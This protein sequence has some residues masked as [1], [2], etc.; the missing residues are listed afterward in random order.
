M[1]ESPA[2]LAL[3]QPRFI[4]L[5]LH[6]S[7][8]ML[9]GAI[10]VKAMAKLCEKAGVPAAALT[11]HGN[12]FGALEF[13]ETLAKAGVQ[14]IIGCLLPLRLES[15]GN[16]AADPTILLLAQSE[17]GYLHLLKLTSKSFLESGADSPHVLMEDL[18]R[19]SEGLIC[20][21]GGAD[22]PA[23]RLLRSDRRAMA[24]AHLEDLARLYPDRLYVEIQRH[25]TE[26]RKRAPDEEETE[27]AFL[28]M[29]YARDL[30]IVATQDTLYAAAEMAEAHDAMLCIASG[31]RVEDAERVR[32]TPE[33][34]FKSPEQMAA[35]FADLPEALEATVEIARRCAHRPKT[36]KPIL[37]RFAPDEVE[38]AR[39]QAEEGL[40]RRLATGPLYAAREA[41]EERLAYELS[42]IAR[43]G[44]SGY[45]LIVSDFI[46]WAKEQGIPVGPGRGSG[47]GSLVAWSLLITD[48]DPIRYG[49][50]FERFL[51]P[52]R[53]S[54]PDF[55][56]D[57]CQEKRH[58]VID[59]VQRKYGR[60]QVA[61]I[62]T[63]GK[64]QARAAL[65]DVGRVLNMPYGQV[66][67]LCKMVPN[68]P[69]KPV[70]I[71]E[72][73]AGEPR[74]R[75]EIR[76]HAAVAK[77]FDIATKLEGLYRHASTHAA[78]VVIGDRPLDELVPLYLDPRSEMPVTQFNMKWVE[79]AG[80]VKFDFLGLK[81]LSVIQEALELIPAPVDI[82]AIS[83][84]DDRTYALYSRAET[85]GVFQVEGTGMRDALRQLRPTSIE[86]IIALVALYRP[87]PMSNIPHYCAVKHGREEPEY[88]H[89]K[90]EPVLKETYGVIIYQEQVME[91]AKLLSGYS[92][93][94][95]DLLRRAMGKKIKAE[96]DQQRSRF[97]EGAVERGLDRAKADEI[98]DL[99]AKF[100]DYGFNK[101]HAAAY[102]LVSYQT[103]WLKANHPLEFMAATMTFDMHNTDKLGVYKQ[104]LDRLGIKLSPPDVNR[105]G[106]KFVTG[107]GEILYALGAVKNVGAEAM[108]G[109][110]RER[111]ANG[112]FRDVF[113]FLRRIDPRQV[114]KRALENLVRAGAFDKL[115]PN[116]H[117]LFVNLDSL[118]A[119]AQSSAA[120][121]AS[122]QNSLF[123]G[124]AAAAPPR[125]KTQEDWPAMEKLDEEQSA[126]G[127]HLSGHPL[128]DFEAALRR[129]KF[130]TL[131]DL[132]HSGAAG[133]RVA[134]VII[135]RQEKKSQSGR[136]FAF[137][138]FSDRTGISE[139]MAF[140]DLL[141]ASRDLLE[142]GR[143]VAL[144][145][146]ADRNGE[147][148]R[149][150]LQAVEDLREATAGAAAECVLIRLT[151]EAAPLALKARLDPARTTRGAE[152]RMTL[153]TTAGPAQ[154]RLPERYAMT[155]DLMS[156]LRSATGVLGVEEVL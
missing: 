40:A 62:I 57:F 78:G 98:F 64:L 125:L 119:Y 92:L 143:L 123:G 3:I 10:H 49:L 100:A 88:L 7:Y 118:L 145:V 1:T 91:I 59:Y 96:M 102:A 133:G 82:S 131:R 75:E 128:D 52:D 104:E 50:L 63:F 17:A 16:A 152:V 70:T 155:P 11:D 97:V 139:G 148:M 61:Q 85:V 150:K 23:G 121:R 72:A 156:S 32:L 137:V 54:M 38:E 106:A 58:F 30:P 114:N 81:T 136:M 46:K 2:P 27:A 74:L 28:E 132:E 9:E 147:Q 142:P 67:K 15:P 25:G 127:F 68:N 84:E 105:S 48:L 65:R 12:L 73:V 36:H 134:V 55:D 126:I 53:V 87:G 80:L 107:E 140:S 66:D 21:T 44:F 69:A 146:E 120:D 90:L 79:P 149:L 153:E 83:L 14:P 130:L 39:R 129:K 135:S 122:G 111:K 35:L 34:Y 19:W 18:A 37:P 41:Y 101:S 8:S 13:S 108:E 33:R 116:R 47:A 6:S 86:D 109:V 94:E 56:I 29:A 141:N 22:G 71:E 103:A 144:A 93:G 4:P 20:L 45:F 60:D 115:E 110:V 43:M 31:A 77:L 138:K 26:G 51:N 112:P 76:S 5:R 113:D 24:E 154:I 42:I 89:P 117:K 124:P 151:P 99:L 95:A